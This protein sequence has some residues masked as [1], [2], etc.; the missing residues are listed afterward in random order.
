MT[1][2]YEYMNTECD[3]VLGSLMFLKLDPQQ[4]AG[5]ETMVECFRGRAQGGKLVTGECFWM[6]STAWPQP[7]P[8]SFCFVPIPRWVASS[9]SFLHLTIRPKSTEPDT[10]VDW[11]QEA[12]QL[13]LPFTC[14]SQV[15]CYRCRETTMPS[16]TCSQFYFG[17]QLWPMA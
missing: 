7:L 16:K 8:H 17:S 10:I 2:E 4:V 3:H 6:S 15:F 11:N 12:E 9:T 5:F 14:I 13:L 1:C